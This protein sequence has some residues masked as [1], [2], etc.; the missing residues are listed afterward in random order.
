[1]RA[2]NLKESIMLSKRKVIE[3]VTPKRMR[4]TVFGAVAVTLT[5]LVVAGVFAYVTPASTAV[6]APLVD[7]PGIASSAAIEP[8][9]LSAGAVDSIGIETDL[10]GNAS[11]LFASDQWCGL[12]ACA[13]PRQP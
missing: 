4:L 2:T 9:N 8:W 13:D 10:D 12:P 6:R 7:Q 5:G 1:M 11:A 3:P